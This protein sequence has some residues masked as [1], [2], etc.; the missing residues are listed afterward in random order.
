MLL[1]LLA[2]S[3]LPLAGLA[4]LGFLPLFVYLAQSSAQSPAPLPGSDGAALNGGGFGFVAA[5][6]GSDEFG[7]C[8]VALLGLCTGYLTCSALMLGPGCVHP[9]HRA[10]AGQMMVGD[11]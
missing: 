8:A 4:H 11:S 9:K 1:S 6:L 2:E 5:V 7:L 3:T 10:L